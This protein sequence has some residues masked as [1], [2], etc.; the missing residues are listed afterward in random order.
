MSSVIA[1]RWY[2]GR[3]EPLA[4]TGFALAY[5]KTGDTFGVFQLQPLGEDKVTPVFSEVR[6]AQ[7]FAATLHLAGVSMLR[8]EVCVV[9]GVGIHRAIIDPDG[10]SVVMSIAADVRLGAPLMN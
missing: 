8:Y 10:Q 4:K 9:H 3:Y 5:K 1:N 7:A 6:L 2:G